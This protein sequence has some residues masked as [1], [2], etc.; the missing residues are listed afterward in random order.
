MSAA[1]EACCEQ[2]QR[3]QEQLAWHVAV[4]RRV[5]GA[6]SVIP[7]DRNKT[8]AAIDLNKIGFYLK[9]DAGQGP[10]R[11]NVHFNKDTRS[12]ML[13]CVLAARKK[14]QDIVG[15]IVI[16]EAEKQVRLGAAADDLPPALVEL[17]EAE[18]EWLAQ[19]FDEQLDPSAVTLEA[20]AAAMQTHRSSTSAS[21]STSAFLVLR[22][23][24]LCTLLTGS[25][26]PPHAVQTSTR[27]SSPLSSFAIDR[28]TQC[29]RA[30][31]PLSFASTRPS[32]SASA[33]VISSRKSSLRSG[34]ESSIPKANT[35]ISGSRRCG[36]VWR[37]RRTS[38]A[39]SCCCPTAPPVH[40]TSC[41]VVSAMASFTILVAASSAL[42]ATGRRARRPT[43]PRWSSR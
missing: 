32:P 35:G 14:V 10:R 33:S 26:A 13:A 18:K 1:A 2:D 23:A 24:Q 36:R 29:A 6:T 11:I 12:S 16:L 21:T 9:L 30:Y 5:P 34:S 15:E 40:L 39:Q 3:E 43:R 4:L 8:G 37:S 20:A 19:W 28:R 31:A 41:R 25:Y 17:S 42:S 7:Y 38:G 22:E 27:A